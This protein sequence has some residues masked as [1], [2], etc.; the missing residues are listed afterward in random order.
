MDILVQDELSYYHNQ[1]PNPY[2]DKLYTDELF[3][4]DLVSLIGIND[5]ESAS[6]SKAIQW[7]RLSEIFKDHHYCLFNEEISLN[8]INQGNVGNCYFISV[9]VSLINYQNVIKSIF[10][11]MTINKNGYYELVFFIDGKSQIV[12]IDDFV[13]YNIIQNELL[14]SKPNRNEVWVVLIEKA[15]AK[16]LGGYH[17]MIGGY[18]YVAFQTLTGFPSKRIFTDD[19]NNNKDEI[20][21]IINTARDK[22]VVLCCNSKIFK[23]KYDE[24]GLLSNHAYTI[25]QSDLNEKNEKMIQIRNPWGK[26]SKQCYV[27][28]NLDMFIQKFLSCDLCYI[29]SSK[30]NIKTLDISEY[31][32]LPIVFNLVINSNTNSKSNPTSVSIHKSNRRFDH[33]K[34]ICSS[35]LLIVKVNED[36]IIKPNDIVGTFESEDDLVIIDSFKKG[37]Y[38]I[39]TYSIC[40]DVNSVKSYLKITSE[41]NYNISFNQID[42]SFYF[43]QNILIESMKFKCKNSI[44]KEKRNIISFI[45]TNYLN[46]GLN[47]RIVINDSNNLS[48]IWKNNTTK[49]DNILLL[50]PYDNSTPFEF[51]VIPKSTVIVIGIRKSKFGHFWF[52]LSSSYKTIKYDQN[53]STISNHRFNLQD[54]QAKDIISND[55]IRMYSHHNDF[56]IPI[57]IQQLT[58]LA[59]SKLNQLPPCLNESNLRWEYK[60][61]GNGDYYG[62]VN[63]LGKREGRGL[64]IFKSNKHYYIGY[65]F[66]DMKHGIGFDYNEKDLLYFK[67]IYKNNQRNG[68]GN[69][70]WEN[71]DSFHGFFESDKKEGFGITKWNNNT[72]WEGPLSKGKLNGIGLFYPSHLSSTKPYLMQF[73]NDKIF[74]SSKKRQYKFE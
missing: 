33:D 28:L 24:I 67:G 16:V 23:E 26:R 72:K 37:Y 57:E 7:K 44:E 27:R 22:S 1:L 68:F 18:P 8:D 25:T 20:W 5:N 65:W 13:P 14:F 29:L 51:Q 15:W 63:N 17:N 21:Q 9:L 52:N 40:S 42:T 39:Y 49:L 54:Y 3:P 48:Q 19:Y 38:L 47:F 71:G 11:S 6:Y 60:Q 34:V 74:H 56:Q 36:N 55:Y 58:A 35:V 41:S 45:E 10:K 31:S 50:P 61:C 43:L 53:E 62:S 30:V 2:D 46:T 59:L 32:H 70:Y 12:I 73:L 69:L 4:P 66:N 64:Y